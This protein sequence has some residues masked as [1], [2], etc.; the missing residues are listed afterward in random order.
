MRDEKLLFAA[1]GGVIGP[2]LY[3]GLDMPRCR[4]WSS[5]GEGGHGPGA[6][7][8][9]LSGGGWTN[10]EYDTDSMTTI[11]SPFITCRTP[12]LY[13]VI[14][15]FIFGGNPNAADNIWLRLQDPAQARTYG[16]MTTQGVNPT[17]F[18]VYLQI[19][20]FWP[21]NAGNQIGVNLYTNTATDVGGGIDACWMSACMISTLG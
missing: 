20:A 15:N 9:P 8:A 17:T 3:R 7:F 12:G 19:Q 16:T 1:R 10:A 11:A 18:G 4:V 6:A 21:A 2:D 14:A 5:T 13:L